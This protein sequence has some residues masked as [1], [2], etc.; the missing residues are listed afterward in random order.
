VAYSQ[1]TKPP[2]APTNAPPAAA[3]PPAAATN[4]A[5]P[6]AAAKVPPEQLDSL[7]AP[8]ALYPDP[9]LAQVLAASTYPLE[10]VQLQQWLEKNQ[11]LKD[12][13]L[14]DAVMKQPWDASVQALAKLP[15][16]IKLLANDISWTT[17]LGNAVLAQQGD[18]MDAVQR[19]RK[20]AKD[21]KKLATT[22]QQVV[23]TKVVD[24]KSVVVIE[25]ANPEVVYVPRMTRL[26]SGV[27]RIIPIRPFTTRL[28]AEPPSLLE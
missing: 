6:D 20:K 1:A 8:I 16:V 7:V 2:A 18:V 5:A 11:G 22:E 15:D 14:A 24:N 21:N 25:Q 26:W 23:E 10:I 3:K 13:A 17:D 27:R 28:T 12:Q 19:M 4:A 9:L